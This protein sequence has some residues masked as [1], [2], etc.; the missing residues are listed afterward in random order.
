MRLVIPEIANPDKLHDF[1]FID[2]GVVGAIEREGVKTFEYMTEMWVDGEKFE[3]RFFS[4]NPTS[5]A[6]FAH[7]C[8]VL[9]VRGFDLEKYREEV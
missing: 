1:I 6:R 3:S 8:E 2:Q 5:E 7:D 9:K 4:E